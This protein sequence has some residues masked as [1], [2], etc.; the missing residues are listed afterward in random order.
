MGCCVVCLDEEEQVVFNCPGS[1]CTYEMC[2]SCIKIAFQDAAGSN[3]RNCPSCK[4]P[5][6]SRMIESICGPG[7][8]REVER[9]V[10]NN[11]EFEVKKQHMKREKGRIFMNE[12]KVKARLLYH[13][14][15]ESLNMK[16]PR[17]SSVF[18]DYEGCNAL[19]CWKT[20]CR[21]AFCAICLQDCGADAHSHVR[22]NHGHD[23]FDK[24]A[25]KE[26][27]KL[28]EMQTVKNFMQEIAVEPFEVRELVKIEFEK[29]VSPGIMPTLTG[30]TSQRT[31]RF[32]LNA[33]EDLHRAVRDDRLSLLSNHDGGW[34]PPPPRIP[35]TG[36]SSK[37]ISPRNAIPENYRLSL[38]PKE[39][40]S[41]V[42]SIL[43]EEKSKEGQWKCQPLPQDD[44][45][46]GVEQRNNKPK[47][48]SLSNLRS[49][50]MCAVIAFRGYRQLIQSSTVVPGN[51]QILEPDQ[52]CIQLQAVNDVGEVEGN[53]LLEN[54]AA[55][56]GG[57]SEILGLNP[58]RRYL[59][60]E[61][62]VS[63]SDDT[64]L[65]F[66]ALETFVG[67]ITPKRIIQEILV[68]APDTFNGLNAQ[69]QR[70]A[71]PLSVATA[72]EI[73]GP[74]GTGKTKTIT[75][76]VRS[77][78]E[79]TDFSIIV[80]SERNGAIDAIANKIASDCLV[81]YESGQRLPKVVNVENWIH[82]ISFGSSGA[83]GNYTRLFTLKEKQK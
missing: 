34:D 77:L 33:K 36:L 38:L 25:F 58:N 39:P 51:G 63:R 49:S 10:R 17:C 70:A 28:R 30:N 5:T 74:P 66:P 12:S 20:D 24:T 48:D 52:I 35:R 54:I 79:C 11:V 69:Q 78:L 40:G 59:L 46:D 71:H 21:A 16:C 65:L 72:M 68:P 76:L 73:A 53:F 14:L 42:C 75:E 60:L 45:D 4:T 61:D 43:L 23:L 44:D 37:D 1:K 64:S 83:I 82:V 56:T 81:M 62:H 80:L 7:A 26:A 15:A 3:A 6:A 19:T 9:E 31:R 57:I 18:V 32:L 29:S 27:K 67:R 50:L 2:A 13:K 41:P 55:A 8:V 47:V 22:E